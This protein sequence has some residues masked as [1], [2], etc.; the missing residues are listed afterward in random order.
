MSRYLNYIIIC[1]LGLCFSCEEPVDWP[2]SAGPEGRLVV[3]AI[4]T[5]QH[6]FQKF[7]LTQNRRAANGEELG[8]ADAQVAISSPQISLVFDADQQDPGS[9]VSKRPF[10]AQ[11]DVL[12]TLEIIWRD[13]AYEASSQLSFVAPLEQI[14]IDRENEDSL[15]IGE[16]APLYHPLQ[17]A[18]HEVQVDWTHISMTAP[19]RAG[20]FFY[21]FSTIDGS[22]LLRPM[23][24]DIYF[25]KGTKVMRTKYG[26]NDDFAA[27]LR[28]FALETIWQGGFFDEASSSLPTNISNGGLGFFSVCATLQDS[29][30]AF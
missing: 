7:R 15:F 20:L 22:E 16:V 29:L 24:E 26:L 27:Y 23:V 12:Y 30:V 5:N 18:M 10:A 4:L 25:P 2:L 3:E 19:N 8:V 14:I 17:Q 6:T 1:S 11:K 13:E 9:Y 28:S 21:T